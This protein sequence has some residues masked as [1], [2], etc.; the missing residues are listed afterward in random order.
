MDRG[1]WLKSIWT[2]KILKHLGL[3]FIS[4]GKT[5]TSEFVPHFGYTF[6]MFLY[7]VAKHSQVSLFHILGIYSKCFYILWQNT[8]K[9]VCSTFWVYIQN[10]FIS[11]GKT[12]TSEFVPHF[13]YTFKMFFDLINGG[14][15]KVR[16]MFCTRPAVCW[17]FMSCES[18]LSRKGIYIFTKTWKKVKYCI[19]RGS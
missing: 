16:S 15:D 5:L 4:C 6:K 9:W 11:C 13:G 1:E 18:E 17:L 7:P 19:H 12:L 14:T 3:K 10:V 8:H 2:N